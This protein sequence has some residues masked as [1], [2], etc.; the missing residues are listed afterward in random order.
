[1]AARSGSGLTGRL[2]RDERLTRLATRHAIRH[3]QWPVLDRIELVPWAVAWACRE[4]ASSERAARIGRP[5]VLPVPTTVTLQCRP[6]PVTV[7]RAGWIHDVRV[8]SVPATVTGGCNDWPI[9]VGLLAA[10]L[11]VQPLLMDLPWTLTYRLCPPPCPARP[12]LVA[13]G[14]YYHAGRMWSIDQERHDSE[15]WN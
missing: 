2:A 6:G 4:G 7:R 14:H 13:G 15:Q 3:R 1:M 11:L 9:P 8:N 10:G 5:A 12:V